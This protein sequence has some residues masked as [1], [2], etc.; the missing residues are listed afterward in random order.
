AQRPTSSLQDSL[1]HDAWSVEYMLAHMK[2][3]ARSATPLAGKTLLVTAGPTRERIDDVRF[4]SN[5]SSGKMG[6]A[7]AEEAA[8][9]GARVILVSGP[10]DLATPQGVERIDV[11]SAAQMHEE[12]L[13]RSSE[14]DMAVLAAAVADFAPA[15][16]VSGKIKKEDAG[17][18]PVIELTRTPDILSSL[19]AVKKAHQLL[20]GFALESANEIDN[21]RKKLVAKNCDL[22]VVN[23][24]SSHEPAMGGDTNEIV[25]LRRTAHAPLVVPRSS[26][27][28]CARIILAAMS[29]ASFPTDTPA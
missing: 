15:R 8:A 2:G 19:G 13:K 11:E 14:Y 5:Y 12:V 4:L 23:S 18:H 26:K 21:G 25:I 28:D 20:V 24:S 3:R 9:Q 29:A 16:A 7:L 10:V 22:I 6:Y 17:S 27:R 1:D